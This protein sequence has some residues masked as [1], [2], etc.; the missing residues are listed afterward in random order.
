MLDI[1][2]KSFSM[3][4]IY[5][6]REMKY[7]IFRRIRRPSDKTRYKVRAK[8]YIFLY[9]IYTFISVVYDDPQF[10]RAVF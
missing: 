5:R 3:S 1:E 2:H 7:R 6:D 4:R 8:F 9:N 10:L